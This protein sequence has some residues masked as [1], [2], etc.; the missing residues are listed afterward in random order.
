MQAAGALRT[1]ELLADQVQ[2]KTANPVAPA[3]PMD[4]MKLIDSANQVRN[5]A[6]TDGRAN[7]FRPV[8]L[9]TALNRTGV[10]H[11][12]FLPLGFD[13]SKDSNPQG[14][15]EAALL[16]GLKI[17]LQSAVTLLWNSGAISR[18]Q[19]TP[20]SPSNREMWIVG[21]SSGNR[22]LWSCLEQNARDVARIVSFDADTLSVGIE[23][24]AAAGDAR[25][26]IGQTL[27]AFVI[28]TPSSGGPQGL[29]D[30]TDLTLRN[31]RAKGVQ[32][33]VLPEFSKR[34]DFWHLNPP[35]IKNPF[36]LYL[37]AKWNVPM[38]RPPKSNPSK[39][40]LDASAEQPARWGFLFFHEMAIFGG[41]LV[42]PPA[43]SPPTTPAKLVTF[44]EQS[45]G[46]PNPRPPP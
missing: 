14:G 45:L 17:S 27:D 41:D 40:L 18:D 19:T 31:L 12:L 6:F 3:D 24:M 44:F 4:L 46:S 28:V 26:K 1:P 10:A 11:L 32:V 2:P 36:L 5:E 7:A 25:K 34:A 39:T 23:K 20:L 21:H 37:L 43:T 15:Y 22:S 8:G 42:P 33:T 35:P 30:K 9:E 13:A 29:T 38:S 16:P